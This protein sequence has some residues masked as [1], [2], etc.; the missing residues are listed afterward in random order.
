M[1]ELKLEVNKLERKDTKQTVCTSTAPPLS[2]TCADMGE[3]FQA[4]MNYYTGYYH[5]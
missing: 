4:Y 2:F 1:K 5:R 3:I